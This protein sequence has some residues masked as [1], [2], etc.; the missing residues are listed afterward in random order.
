LLLILTSSFQGQLGVLLQAVVTLLPPLPL[1][2]V[3]PE[4]VRLLL[5]LLLAATLSWALQL[6]FL[7]QPAGVCVLRCQLGVLR[8]GLAW[9]GLWSLKQV[10]LLLLLG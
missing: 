5:L 6:V 1:P 2:L 10:L 4:G 7:L 3:L 8:H 9:V